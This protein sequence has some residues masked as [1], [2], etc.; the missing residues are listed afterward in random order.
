MEAQTS[1]SKNENIVVAVVVAA[2]IIDVAVAIIGS[3]S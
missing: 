2:A 3:M 1:L